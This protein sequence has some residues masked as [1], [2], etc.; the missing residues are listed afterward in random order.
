P[1]FRV[2]RSRNQ[3]PPTTDGLPLR[4]LRW[5]V[6]LE[7]NRYAVVIRCR[8]TRERTAPE[9]AVIRAAHFKHHDAVEVPCFWRFSWCHALRLVHVG[10]SGLGGVTKDWRLSHRKP[11][12]TE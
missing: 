2:A 12:S 8:E 11:G 3:R 9:S 6:S 4:E 5:S 1:A 10:M 7:P